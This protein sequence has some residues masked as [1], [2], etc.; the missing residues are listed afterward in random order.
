VK[1][2]RRGIRN[3]SIFNTDEGKGPAHPVLGGGKRRARRCARSIEKKNKICC[4]PNAMARKR[5][6][7]KKKKEKGRE[8]P[9]QADAT[10]QP[11]RK[12][13][14]GEEE[15]EPAPSASLFAP[16]RKRIRT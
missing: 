16:R 4:A 12:K 13:G 14:G 15:G 8:S 3:A 2:K 1:E 7:K 6:R 9:S 10:G 11:R 5:K